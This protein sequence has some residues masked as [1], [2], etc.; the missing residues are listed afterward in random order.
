M[1]AYLS[2][3]Q[4]DCLLIAFSASNLWIL[5][6]VEAA[7]EAVDIVVDSLTW[8]LEITQEDAVFYDRDVV[9][10]NVHN[11]LEDILFN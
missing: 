1:Y 5:I 6:L 9:V 10:G 7:G 11:I 8:W 3:S 2:V 4:A